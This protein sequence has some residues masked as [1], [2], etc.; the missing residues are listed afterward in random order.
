MPSILILHLNRF[1]NI[2]GLRKIQRQVSFPLEGLDISKYGGNLHSR[3]DLYAVSNHYGTMQSGHYTA[4]CKVDND[5][6]ISFDDQNTSEV[7]ESR[8]CSP[9]AHIL[10]YKVTLA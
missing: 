5:R 4:N 2:T 8:V 6:W 9:A 1:I 10:F 3:L 7:S